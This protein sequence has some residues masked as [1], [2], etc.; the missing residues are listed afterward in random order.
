MEMKSD[1]NMQEIVDR[2]A[3][4]Q[5]DMSYVRECVEDTTLTEE[6]LESIETAEQELKEG[7]TTSLEDLKRE[8][9]K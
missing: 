2:L 1:I 3:K 4:L 8:L 6:D 7:K 5:A 9:K